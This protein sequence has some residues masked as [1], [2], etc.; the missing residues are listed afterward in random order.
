MTLP[1]HR[2]EERKKKDKHRV[3]TWDY[4]ETITKSPDRCARIAKGLNKI[5]DHNVV[6]TG[7][8]SSR[9]QLVKNLKDF[10]FPFDD[11]IQYED[12][13][14]DGIRRLEVL[15]QLDAWGAFDDRAGRAPTLTQQCPHFFLS[16][17]PSDEAKEKAKGAKK[18][19]KKATKGVRSETRSA[20]PAPPNLRQSDS[21]EGDQPEQECGT[22]LMFDPNGSVCWG[23]GNAEDDG[24]QVSDTWELDP[25]WQE[26]D[27]S[28]D[29]DE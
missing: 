28:Q 8:Q 3:W 14:T 24:E 10:D 2:F 13:Q 12:D 27:A 23:Y 11:L 6:V 5:G 25:N 9:D 4:D 18:A 21:T 29:A 7:N 1:A 22:C 16:A 17:E 15:E 26:Q 20:A 19:A